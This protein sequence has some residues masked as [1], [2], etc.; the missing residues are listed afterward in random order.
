MAPTTHK[1]YRREGTPPPHGVFQ[2]NRSFHPASPPR[3]A[4]PPSTRVLR[5]HTT[6]ATQHKSTASIR[7]TKVTKNT[8]KRRKRL[9]PWY[10]KRKVNKNPKPRAPPATYYTCRICISYLPRDDFIRWVPPR[11]SYGRL[12]DAPRTCISHL[13]RDPARRNNPV[14]KVCVGAFM[15]ARLDTH[16]ARKVSEGCMEPGCTTQWPWEKVIEY[17]PTNRLEEFN[18]ASFEHWRTDAQLF[19]CREPV[20]GFVALIDGWAA[21]GYPHVECP[22]PTCKARSCATCRT[23]WHTDQ[24]CAEIHAA[25]ATAQISDAEKDTLALMQEKDARRCPNCQLVIEKDGGCSSMRCG[26]CEKFFNWEEAASAVPGARKSEPQT[27]FQ[28]GLYTPH[29]TVC[30]VDGLERAREQVFTA[31]ET[32]AASAGLVC[33]LRENMYPPMPLPDE[34]D[35]DL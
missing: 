30:E 29:A 19:T 9:D 2:P 28:G 24:T 21:P 15:A 10:P 23:A 26:G 35:A 6:K 1:G 13:A 12:L 22:S 8:T 5:S 11:R 25:A 20:C 27:A 4:P 33:E 17:F 34:D 31:A 14:C 16:G 32:L 3:R 18:L 7:S